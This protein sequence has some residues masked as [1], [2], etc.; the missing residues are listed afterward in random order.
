MGTGKENVLC[1]K[2][3]SI[4]RLGISI[5]AS[6]RYQSI[7]KAINSLVYSRGSHPVSIDRSSSYVKTIMEWEHDVGV[8]STVAKLLGVQVRL[9][10]A[11]YW[12]RWCTEKRCQW[13]GKNGSESSYLF[14]CG[15]EWCTCS[16][17]WCSGR[18]LKRKARTLRASTE[19]S[20]SKAR[21]IDSILR[22]IGR[23]NWTF[24]LCVL[25]PMYALFLLRC[26]WQRG[27]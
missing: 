6:R 26:Y 2:D 22:D 16:L 12:Q 25:K 18:K 27:S 11:N 5:Q 20:E 4:V 7:W 14:E 21:S 3:V 15:L 23:L 9:C 10:K 13:H 1:V 17:D 8:Y 24:V 19:N